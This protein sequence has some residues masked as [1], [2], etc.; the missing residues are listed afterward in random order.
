MP[1]SGQSES[2]GV[3]VMDNLLRSLNDLADIISVLI[4]T[5][6][7]YGKPAILVTIWVVAV[8]VCALLLARRYRLV[9]TL[10]EQYDLRPTWAFIAFGVV[11][12]L[13]YIFFFGAPYF[14]PRYHQPL[15]V[16]W[17]IVFSCALPI[18]YS[19]LR[20]KPEIVAFWT[21]VALIVLINVAG[22]GRYYTR[23]VVGDYYRAGMWCFDDPRRYNRHR[24]V[25]NSRVYRSKRGQSRRQSQH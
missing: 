16:L 4:L 9:S 8:P 22:I 10:V 1:Q 2:L 11:L 14:I 24:T 3:P 6:P 23:T 7:Y 19:A 17:T 15:R 20:S 13:Y 12:G 18:L 25:R 21:L 5:T